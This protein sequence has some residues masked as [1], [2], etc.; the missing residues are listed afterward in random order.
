MKFIAD[1][2]I[3]SHYSIAT[4]KQLNPEYLDY[5]ARIK[6][7]TIVGTGDFTHPGWIDELNEKL[8]PAEPGLF[9]LKNQYKLELPFKIPSLPETETRFLLT[10]EISNIYKKYD[11]VRKVHNVIFAP[12]FQT[13]ERIQNELTKHNFNI[14][15]DGRP[16][17]GLDSRDLLEMVLNVSENIFF[18][19]AHIWTPWFSALGAKSGFDTIDECY[20]DLSEYIF[21]VETGLSSDPRMNWM[22]SFLD[23]YTLISNSDAHSPEKLGREAN[24]FDTEISYYGIIE[25][26]K[27]TDPEHFQ[28]TIEFFPQE[29]KYHY[30]GHRKCGIC[31]NPL[32]TL[33]NEGK[34]SVCGK[35]VTVGVMNRVTQLADRNNA[36]ERKRRP[37]FYSMIPL[38]EILSEI[39]GVGPNSKQVTNFYM[40][41][42]KKAGTEFNVL[43]YLQLD[44]IKNLGYELLTEA[45]KRMRNKEVYIQEGFDGEFGK[46]KVFKENEYK[47]FSSQVSLF[48]E[49]IPVYQ[50][51]SE[52]N[53]LINFDHE[54]FTELNKSQSN[55]PVD[56]EKNDNRNIENNNKD[57]NPKLNSDQLSAVKHFNGPSLIIAGPGTGKTRVLTNR[58]IYLIREKGISPGH[59]LAVTFTNKAADEIK[60]RIQLL[61]KDEKALTG[62]TV[63]TFHAFGLS[64]LKDQMHKTGRKEHFIIIDQDD[65][66][67]ILSHELKCEKG[68]I[69]KISDIITD[70][71]QNVKSYDEIEDKE[72]AD[73]FIRYDNLLIDQNAFDLDDLI[74]LPVCILKNNP[75]ILEHYKQRILWIMVDEFQDINYNQYQLIRLLMQ[76]PDSNLCVIGDPNQAIYGFRG[77]NVQFINNFRKDYPKT[78]VFS[79]KTSYRCTENILKASQGIIEYRSKHQHRLSDFSTGTGSTVNAN[80]YQTPLLEGLQKGIKINVSQYSSEKSEAEFIARTI[81]KMIGGLRFFSMDSDIT[82]GSESAEINSLSDFAVLCRISHQLKSLEK[83]FHDHNIPYQT[84]GDKPFLKEEPVKS[85]IDIMKCCMNS[86]NRFL[87]NKL[88]DKMKIS[89]SDIIDVRNHINNQSVYSTIKMIIDQIVRKNEKEYNIGFKR[90]MEFSK[91]FES[92]FDSFFK[93]ESLGTSIDLYRPNTENVSLMTL[94]A[95]KGLEFS[96]VF[97]PGCEEGLLPYSIFDETRSDFDEEK[98]LLYVGMTRAKKYLFLCHAEKRFL[99]GREL[100]LKRSPFLDSIEEELI[101]LSNKIHKE[102]IKKKDDQLKLF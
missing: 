47:H 21:A 15:S 37:D 84:V 51:K 98:R 90:L 8:E 63:S 68:R 26:L 25:A 31:W 85:V 5:W 44:E 23:K 59:I 45:I 89:E 11:K 6:G 102:K 91:N 48:K 73:I 2:H 97:I 83:A 67:R 88:F 4:S 39:S 20:D 9:R 16:I 95:A 78:S 41:I 74:Y 54:K 66:R 3:H 53:K 99:F 33:K 10:S 93:V 13:V 56:D 19:P 79:L 60:Q 49:S 52:I 28:G 61:L 69:S 30:D 96:C 70:I 82:E 1:F 7:I 22:C 42:M 58:I 62:L 94:H 27:S 87:L 65:R 55:K 77:A 29:G 72:I 14:T 80:E 46:I 86:Q 17:L 50:P 81:E 38:K 101:V 75:D 64:V 36:D 12:D 24:L 34:C 76:N 71:K 18:V 43:L 92:D 32:E 57:S 100:H 35:K 40:S